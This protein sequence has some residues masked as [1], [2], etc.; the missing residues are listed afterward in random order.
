MLARSVLEGNAAIAI[1]KL[2]IREPLPIPVF[3]S[4]WDL[5]DFCR[6]R[7][8]VEI[9][10]MLDFLTE[11][12]NKFHFYLTVDDLAS[13]LKTGNCALLFDGLDEVPTDSGRALISRLLEDL[14]KKFPDNRYVVTSRIRAYTGDTILKGDFARCDI[15]PFDANDRAEFLKNWTALLF[16]IQPEMVLTENTDAYREFHSLTEGI[17]SNDRI[18]SL[19]INPLLL[20]VIAIVHW[21]RKRLP[22]QRVDLYDECVDVLLGQRKEAEQ[23]QTTRNP[24]AFQPKV[25]RLHKE[26][27]PWIRKRFAEIALKV[28]QGENKREEASKSDI[29]KLLAPRFVDRGAR[30]LEEGEIQAA[31]FLDQQELRSGLL[32]SRR[33]YSYR[34]V[35]L[36]FQEYLAAWNLSNQEFDKVVPII[37][38]HLREQRWFEPLQLLGGEWAKHSDEKLDTYLKWLLAH[39][40]KSIMARAPVVALCANIVKDSSGIAELTPKTRETFRDAVESTLDAFKPKSGVPVVT[41]LEI[42][43]A[44]GKLGAAVKSHLID[45]TKSGL[46]Q[47]RGRAIEMLLPHLSDDELFGMRHV[48]DDRSKVPIKSFLSCLL[49]RDKQRIVLILIQQEQ[50]SQKAT[51]A[52]TEMVKEFDRKLKAADF[53]TVVRH[54]FQRG[55]SYYEGYSA[56]RRKLLE[57]LDDEVLLFKSITEDREY[58]VREYSLT[59]IA[60][61]HFGKAETRKVIQDVLNSDPNHFVRST[62]ID[63]LTAEVVNNADNWAIVDG[64]MRDNLSAGIRKRALEFMATRCRYEPKM[65]ARL[66]ETVRKAASLDTDDEVRLTALKLMAEHLA[67]EPQTWELVRDIIRKGREKYR[68]RLEALDWLVDGR[69]QDSETWE[70]ITECALHDADPLIRK[71]A[72]TAMLAHPKIVESGKRIFGLPYLWADFDP[73]NCITTYMI[74]RHVSAN[75]NENMIRDYFELLAGRLQEIFGYNLRF[76][77]SQDDESRA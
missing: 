27:R 4:C 49:G 68:L 71:R 35:H 50:F 63:L 22:E 75:V 24:F 19:A 62:C 10:G 52:F 61:R 38:P 65:L 31:S 8:D 7:R 25:E 5:S 46:N 9:S 21:N 72:F 74:R 58:T 16:K 41:Q 33:E 17:E 32:V 48:L 59:E 29:L 28:L 66:R 23:V 77:S 67:D 60:K 56:S 39:Q 70:L 36:T 37:Q 43:E 73:I 34:F 55:E 11:R 13:L 40:G 51:D 12:L 30:T 42:L 76:E 26:E 15:Q 2:C 1:D 54:V 57:R 6:R 64:V 69:K 20:T 44:L 53:A 18:R 14:V 47:V 3:V 45:A